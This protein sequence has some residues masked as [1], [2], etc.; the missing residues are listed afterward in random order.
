MNLNE[1]Q[2]KRYIEIVKSKNMDDMFDFGREIGWER[3][4]NQME[5]CKI[6]ESL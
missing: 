4:M 1:E 6:D 3:G 5:Q 2:S